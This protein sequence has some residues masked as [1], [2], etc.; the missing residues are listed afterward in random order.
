M[1]INSLKTIEVELAILH[2][3]AAAALES[4]TLGRLDRAGYLILHL[5]VSN[6]PA[7]MKALAAQANLDI[8]TVSRQ[9]ATLEKNKC[10]YKIPDPTDR[11]AYFLRITELGTKELNSYKEARLTKLSEVLTDW[12]EEERN[13]FGRLLTKFNQQ[14][15]VK[16]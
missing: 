11:R 9:A 7:G 12:T 5:I 4:N 10:V 6:G 1:D 14:A 3:K 13:V 16:K 15:I 2:R 8:S